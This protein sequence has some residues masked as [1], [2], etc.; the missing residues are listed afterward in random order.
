MRA[1]TILCIATALM[2]CGCVDDDGHPTA[3]VVADVAFDVAADGAADAGFCL[4]LG[5]ACDPEAASC[6]QPGC[7]MAPACG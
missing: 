3:V 1:P 7:C 2:W 6:C 4:P 5:M